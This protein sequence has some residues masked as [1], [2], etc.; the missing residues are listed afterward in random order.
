[1]HG[2]VIITSV[3]LSVVEILLSIQLILRKKNKY[4]SIIEIIL[5]YVVQLFYLLALHLEWWKIIVCV[6]VQYVAVK[7]FLVL[8]MIVIV[9]IGY[10]LMIRELLILKGV[11][12]GIMEYLV[13]VFVILV[14]RKP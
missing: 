4:A 13:L 7:A 1:M 14:M 5:S 6:L 9:R 12:K 3:I 11:L 10:V 2:V 8:F